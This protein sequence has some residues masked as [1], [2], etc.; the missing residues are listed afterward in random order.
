MFV[1]K[2]RM[3][4]REFLRLGGAGLAGAGLLLGG[5]GCGGGEGSG[6]NAIGWQAIPSY[7]PQAPD[8]K[9]VDYLN[10]SIS[11]WEESYGEFAINPLISSSDVTVAMARLLKQAN[12]DRA[13]DIAQVD[14][15]VFPR[16]YEYVYPLDE[17]LEDS[18]V[19]NDYFP[20]VESLILGDGGVIKGL[21]FTTDVR[22]LYHRKDLVPEP[23]ASWDEVLEA[24]R[25]L[26]SEG[27]A[28]Y[29]FP[30]GR[31]EATV[32]TSLWPYFWAQGGELLDM[33]GNPVFGEGENR[34]KM[35]GCLEFIRE[36]VASGITP[37]RTTTYLQETDLNAD[38]NA[39]AVG[40]FLGG[41]WQVGILKEVT[42]EEEF[43]STWGVA[44]IPSLDGGTHSTTAGGWIWG[45]FAGD[46]AKKRAAVDFL[47]YTFVGD[48]GMAGWCNAGGYL[49]PRQS[50]FDLSEYQGNEYTETFREHLDKYARNRPASE[51]YQNI[52][53]AM[54]VAVASVITED[55][56]PE[57]ALETAVRSV[58]LQRRD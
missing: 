57:Q 14:S 20:F 48:R 4:R 5:A 51:A 53:T 25:D 8:P 31:D 6:E 54:Q 55:A 7:S 42:G 21:Q 26:K 22:V 18:G 19:T 15:Y 13:P 27:L 41:N 38:I 37:T 39:G 1:D 9:R 29:L 2:R 34:E 33:D 47:L 43:T 12:E 28:P 35:L 46:E 32:T 30:A 52:S 45:I 17:Y 36:C 23:P 50:V 58:S 44:P 10:Q 11:G 16:F 24:G 3:S 56:S 40:M 49:P